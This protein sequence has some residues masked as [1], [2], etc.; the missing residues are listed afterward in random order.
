MLILSLTALAVLALLL[1]VP[2]TRTLRAAALLL[3]SCSSWAGAEFPVALE[4]LVGAFAGEALP[5]GLVLDEQAL[6]ARV[7]AAARARYDSRLCPA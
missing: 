4:L 1:M 3:R 7:T 5:A 2:W 6:R